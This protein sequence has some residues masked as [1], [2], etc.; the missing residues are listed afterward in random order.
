MKRGILGSDYKTLEGYVFVY[1]FKTIFSSTG[2][3]NEM[4]KIVVINNVLM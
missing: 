4:L 1:I 2:H 3:R